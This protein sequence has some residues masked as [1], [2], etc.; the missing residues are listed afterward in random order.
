MVRRSAPVSR[1][2]ERRGVANSPLSGRSPQTRPVLW[3]P[4]VSSPIDIS[5]H[6]RLI[7]VMIRRLAAC[8]FRLIGATFLSSGMAAAMV[9]GAPPADPATARH[10][11][12]IC[13]LARQFVQRRYDDRQETVA[14]EV[15][16]F[17]HLSTRFCADVL[18]GQI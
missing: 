1:E 12:L 6:P 8:G 13:R 3:Q 5:R 17:S 15:A 4:R 9:G 10:V 7:A 18:L 11:V 2:H 14:G 16:A